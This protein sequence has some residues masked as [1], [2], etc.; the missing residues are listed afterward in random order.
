MVLPT[1]SMSPMWSNPWAFHCGG[2]ADG[3]VASTWRSSSVP[4]AQYHSSAPTF[5]PREWDAS[6]LARRAR[7]AGMRYGVLTTKHHSG[8]AMF[9][10][11]VS[12]FSV[13]QSPFGRDIVSEFVDAFRAEG[14]RVGLYYSLSDWSHPDY[15]AFA[16]EDR[17]Y[18]FG[19]SPA[20]SPEGWP[21]YV[22]YLFAQ[23]PALLT[24]YG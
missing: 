17:P 11:R 7:D 4:A 2:M 9:H 19:L 1:T 20:P 6:A 15:P 13:E 3:S 12:T 8:Y 14:L 23:V 18:S 5:D 21:R 16:D 22:G 10:T 24:N